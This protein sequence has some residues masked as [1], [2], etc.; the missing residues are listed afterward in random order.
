MNYQILAPQAIREA[1]NR[2]HHY[3][4]RTPLLSSSHLNEWLGHDVTF[5]VEAFQKIGAFKIRGALNTLLSLKE[6][7]KLPREIVTFSS[8]NHAQAV[9]LVGSLFGVKTTVFMT[10]HASKIKKQATQGYGASV[11]VTENRREAEERTKEMAEKGACFIHPFDNDMVI[12]GQ[13]TVCY[14]ALSDGVKPDAIFAPCGGGGLLSGTYLAKELLYPQAKLFAGEPAN[15]NDATRSYHSGV[16][17]RYEDS[18][19][20]IADGATSLSVSERTF[21]YL[22]KLDGFFEADEEDIIHWTRWLMH[23]LKTTV[24]P[25]SAVAM[26]AAH[27]WMR[28]QSKRQSILILLSGGNIDPSTYETLWKNHQLMW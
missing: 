13:G 19:K 25:T 22:K 20:T 6:Q 2:I 26:S 5:K 18:P 11:I 28:K 21:H 15:A 24:E 4:H 27:Q 10:Q 8:G 3:I 17:N 23:L 16:I 1:H 9:A 12:A 14:E 7:G